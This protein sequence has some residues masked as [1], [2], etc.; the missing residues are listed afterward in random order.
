MVVWLKERDS[1]KAGVVAQRHTDLPYIYA[2][3]EIFD[4]CDGGN[5][6]GWSLEMTTRWLGCQDVIIYANRTW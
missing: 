6:E 1:C 2:I 5:S 3:M 4:N